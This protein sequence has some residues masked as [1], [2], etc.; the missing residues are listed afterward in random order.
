MRPTRQ[1]KETIFAIF[2]DEPA[3]NK[4]W[5]ERQS[6]R[7]P[8]TIIAWLICAAWLYIFLKIR[9]IYVKKTSMVSRV[10]NCCHCILRDTIPRATLRTSS[11]TRLI[12]LNDR[13]RVRMIS[14]T[15]TPRFAKGRI[16]HCK[17]N[18]SCS[19]VV[20]VRQ[21]LALWK[22]VKV[23]HAAVLAADKPFLVSCNGPNFIIT[24][25]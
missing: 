3:D 4:T 21:R 11:N 24:Y 10:V 12:N 2:L 1:E 15:G 6:P 9:R 13:R 20:V 8:L 25:L 22:I 23:K 7:K 18:A 17:A 19:E 16:Y 5:C 14:A